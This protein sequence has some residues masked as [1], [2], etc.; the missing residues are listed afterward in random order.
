LENEAEKDPELYKNI[1][2]RIGDNPK[3]KYFAQPGDPVFTISIYSAMF[4]TINDKNAN[5]FPF[6]IINEAGKYIGFIAYLESKENPKIIEEIKTF[7]FLKSDIVMANDIIGMADEL[8]T[9]YDQVNWSALGGNS[10]IGTY[11]QY[12]RKKEAEGYTVS[13][14]PSFEVKTIKEF[15]RVLFSVSVMN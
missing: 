1:F 9:K 13:R 11:T 15:E 14:D 6:F 3:Y 2:A 8:I 7:N 12:L 5:F 10:F 4:V